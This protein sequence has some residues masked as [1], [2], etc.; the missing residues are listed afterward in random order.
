[1]FPFNTLFFF[2]LFSR[3]FLI[4]PLQAEEAENPLKLVEAYR[5][6]GRYA[7]ALEWLELNSYMDQAEN[8]QETTRSSLEQKLLQ[9]GASRILFDEQFRPRVKLLKLL[10]T[11]GMPEGGGQDQSPLATWARINAWAQQNLIRSKER[12]E[13]DAERVN[14]F[15]ALRPKVMPFFSDWGFIREW[16]PHFKEYRGALVHGALLPRMRER[17]AYLVEQWKKGVRFTHLYFLSSARPL[18]ERIEWDEDVKMFCHLKRSDLPKTEC[19]LARKLWESADLPVEMRQAVEV[20]FIEAPMKRD[21]ESGAL[22]RPTTD[23][24]VAMWLTLQP[25]PLSG[26]YLVVSNAPYMNRQDVVMRAAVEEAE[27]S[28][29]ERRYG[30]DTVGRGTEE[31]EGTAVFLFLD[32]LARLIYQTERIVKGHFCLKEA[33]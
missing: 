1:M 19:Q 28:V 12:W 7:E 29:G 6:E 3:F 26:R 4:A 2:F 33:N 27:E 5:A 9:F 10:Y 25:R 22:L 21:K 18:D 16:P 31:G 8:E 30:F 23:D 20:S 14:A 17:L 15:Q 11:V 13:E 32:E 24:T